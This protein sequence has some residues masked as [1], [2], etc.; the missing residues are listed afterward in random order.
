MKY[1][2]I[3]EMYFSN[4]KEH[5]SIW[6]DFFRGLYP[7]WERKEFH[8]PEQDINAIERALGDMWKPS[9][10]IITFAKSHPSI[11]KI[12]DNGGGHGR[13]AVALA[14][15]GYD[16]TLFD[17]DFYKLGM[18]ADRIYGR[19]INLEIKQGLSQKLPFVD[20][21]FDMVVYNLVMMLMPSL[22]DV[23]QTLAESYR[24]LK[25][26]GWVVG[27]TEGDK[28]LESDERLE[29][30]IKDYRESGMAHLLISKEKLGELFTGSGF[31]PS[32]LVLE[33]KEATSHLGIWNIRFSAR[34]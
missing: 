24:V 22:D 27:M 31:N 17:K 11:N 19:Y 1:S 20:E 14:E 8:D 4:W 21:E 28:T 6:N 29:K 15:Q 25:P 12:L 13:N 23:R 7:Q 9:K 5:R 2:E 30:W 10:S 26:E 32:E 18:A 16:V 34:K 33:E 3:P